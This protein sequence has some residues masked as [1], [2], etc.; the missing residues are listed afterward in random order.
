MGFVA[1]LSPQ[2]TFLNVLKRYWMVGR[3]GQILKCLFYK[4]NNVLGVPRFPKICAD[5]AL[6]RLLP[7]AFNGT[8][9]LLNNL[10]R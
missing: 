3:V 8:G 4:K 5:K 2:R 7:G 9:K 1:I 10:S 6:N